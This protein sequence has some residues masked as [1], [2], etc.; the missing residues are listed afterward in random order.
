[1]PLEASAG[2]ARGPAAR[3]GLDRHPAGLGLPDPLL[4]GLADDRPRSGLQPGHDLGPGPAAWLGADP[5]RS[6][7]DGLFLAAVRD[8]GPALRL[9]RVPDGRPR[10]TLPSLPADRP[11]LRLSAA[12]VLGG[13]Q[14]GVGGS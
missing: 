11:A 10:E 13:D 9:D 4:P 3:A 6:R 7:L 1:M 2:A 12:H 14:G 8:R 5:Y